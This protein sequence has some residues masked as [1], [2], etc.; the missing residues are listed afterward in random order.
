MQPSSAR[1]AA[2]WADA[3]AKSISH[4]LASFPSGFFDSFEFTSTGNNYC[5]P[6]TW[7]MLTRIMWAIPDVHQVGVD[8]RFNEGKDCKFQPDLVAFDAG[9]KPMLIIDFESPNSS[10]NRIPEKDV[11]AYCAWNARRKLDVP[12][13]I[14]TALPARKTDAWELRY[15]SRDQCNL[16]YSGRRSDICQNPFAFWYGVYVK[17]FKTMCLD[18]IA[19]INIDGRV[20]RRAFPT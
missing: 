10:D 13:L 17:A 16:G 8:M 1:P 14:V 11:R 5:H 9:R 2:V 6:M 4:E 15:T 20:A 3:I 19:L 12:Y 7:G 18:N